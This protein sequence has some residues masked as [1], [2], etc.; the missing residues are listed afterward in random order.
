M[1]NELSE[2]WKNANSMESIPKD[3]KGIVRVGIIQKE[4]RVYEFYRD[5]TG[6]YW[7]KTKIIK[8]GKLLEEQTAIFGKRR[9][10]Q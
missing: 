1:E 4:S 3:R 8:D 6:A 2:A 9:R 5:N 10:K 7:Y